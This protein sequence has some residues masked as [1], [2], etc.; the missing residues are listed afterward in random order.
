[1]GCSEPALGRL[2]AGCQHRRTCGHSLAKGFVFMKSRRPG[3]GFLSAG[4]C[5]EPTEMFPRW[6]AVQVQ[7]PLHVPQRVNEFQLEIRLELS[8]GSRCATAGG[9]QSRERRKRG[10][11]RDR[12]PLRRNSCL[13]RRCRRLDVPRP[14]RSRVG[15]GRAGRGRKKTRRRRAA[16]TCRCRGTLGQ[17]APPPLGGS[18]IAESAALA[19]SIGRRTLPAWRLRRR[20][21]GGPAR[22]YDAGCA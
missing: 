5:T 9:S 7:R 14:L 19:A 11:H 15:G 10:T 12:R 3:T 18:G 20:R 22:P 1:M 17:E 21:R 16:A 13:R 6:N 8:A 2:P 4:H